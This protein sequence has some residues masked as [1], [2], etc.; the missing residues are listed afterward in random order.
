MS[1][2]EKFLMKLATHLSF[3]KEDELLKKYF[4]IWVKV[5]NIVKRY[6]IVNMYTNKI[7]KN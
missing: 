4:K 3:I 6:L 5:C 2:Y 1:G 7:S